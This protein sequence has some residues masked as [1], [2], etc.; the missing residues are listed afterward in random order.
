MRR[1]AVIVDVAI[2]QGG[3]VETIHET[4]HTDPDLRRATASSTTRSATSPAPCPTRRP[5]PSPTPPC[6]TSW[7]WP[8]TGCRG[9]IERDP[10]LRRR[11]QHA[12]RARSPT[13]RWPRP[14]GARPPTPSSSS[15]DV[16][17]VDPASGRGALPLDAEEYL[18]WLAA[19]KGRAPATLAAYRRD[20][21]AY[22][23][24][25]GARGEDLD[26]PSPPPTSRPTSPT[27]GPPAGRRRRWPGPWWP[28]ASLHRF[29]ADEG[30]AA[31]R[32]VDR[33]GG[34][35]GAGRACPRR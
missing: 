29:L 8:S 23:A 30:T 15:A 31:D 26:R 6:P 27:C 1:G 7:P 18:S 34:A 25:L 20:L 4:T 9:A 17:D 21:A 32:P 13:R 3:C 14:S 22:V 2:D 10:A 5:T 19:E 28:C 24:W 11:R 16:T 33:G 35:P 12:W